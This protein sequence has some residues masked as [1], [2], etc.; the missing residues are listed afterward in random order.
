MCENFSIVVFSHSVRDIHG[1]SMR[2]WK[3]EVE[4]NVTVC[5]KI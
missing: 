3:I 2:K 5:K 1:A 4:N